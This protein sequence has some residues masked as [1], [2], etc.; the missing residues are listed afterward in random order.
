M[1]EKPAILAKVVMSFDKLFI[2]VEKSLNS[3]TV[4]LIYWLVISE[5]GFK[6]LYE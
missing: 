4:C 3:M 2:I 6:S 1:C 5:K